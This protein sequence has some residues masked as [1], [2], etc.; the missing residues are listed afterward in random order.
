MASK[1][2]ASG[3]FIS[4]RVFNDCIVGRGKGI[5]CPLK[6]LFLDHFPAGLRYTATHP[7]KVFL[8][9][10]RKCLDRDRPSHE[11]RVTQRDFLYAFSFEFRVV[12]RQTFPNRLR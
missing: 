5:A 11:G 2:T 6:P 8:S 10:A 1:S 4:S 12:G 7:Q 9:L 3:S